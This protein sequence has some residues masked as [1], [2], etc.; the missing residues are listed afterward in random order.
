MTCRESE[1]GHWTG[2]SRGLLLPYTGIRITL[3]PIHPVADVRADGIS[4]SPLEFGATHHPLVSV[5]EA[6][7]DA[8]PQLAGICPPLTFAPT[9]G[10]EVS[11]TQ[12]YRIESARPSSHT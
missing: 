11:G 2:W 8:D 1:P 7:V 12:P 4:P 6:Y 5:S 3:A 9:A 10:M